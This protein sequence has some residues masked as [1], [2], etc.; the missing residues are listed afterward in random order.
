MEAEAQAAQPQRRPAAEAALRAAQAEHTMQLQE[1]FEF[2]SFCIVNAPLTLAL[3]QLEVIWDC[4]VVR[5]CCAEEADLAFS[6][7]EQARLSHR[8]A[9]SGVEWRSWSCASTLT[10]LVIRQR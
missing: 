4:C 3:E 7:I 8:R 6:W 10:A 1:R 9:M 2:L 5:G